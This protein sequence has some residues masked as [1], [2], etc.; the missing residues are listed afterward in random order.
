MFFSDRKP[1]TLEAAATRIVEMAKEA[2]RLNV[3]SSR[4]SQVIII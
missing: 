4:T 3:V 1:I 2:D